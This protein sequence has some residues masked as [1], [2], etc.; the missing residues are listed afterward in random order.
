MDFH[1]KKDHRP[2]GIKVAMRGVPKDLDVICSPG[3]IKRTVDKSETDRL[4][5][6]FGKRMPFLD[7]DLVDTK[8]CMYTCTENDHFLL[9]FHPKYKNLLLV[10]PCSGHGFKFSS[11]IGE[12]VKEMLCDGGSRLDISLFSLEEHQKERNKRKENEERR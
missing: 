11:V 9:D 10:S 1:F 8:T 3:N 7:G 2:G 6:L 12:V 4:R 5:R